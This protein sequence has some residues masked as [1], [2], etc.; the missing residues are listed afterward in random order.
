MR[1]L[2]LLLVLAALAAGLTGAR[3]TTVL[4]P[5]FPELVQN[6][7]YVVRGRVVATRNEIRL[8]EGRE[9]PFTLIEVEVKQ[10]IAGE[11]P[12]RVTLTMLGGKTSDGSEL[13]VEGVPQ[14]TVGDEDILFVRG[15][16]TNFYPLYGVMHGRYPVKFDKKLNREY[17]ARANG[18]PL[19]ATAEVALPLAEGKLAQLLRQQIRPDDALTPGEFVQSIR[20]ARA[21]REEGGQ[22]LA[23]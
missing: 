23:K 7:D 15:N 1:P 21:A 9:L 6:S 12:A 16:G 11:A 14:F 5:E 10:V 22:N 8:R 20:A 18:V 2:R 13:R 4:P 17:I 3:A 19:S